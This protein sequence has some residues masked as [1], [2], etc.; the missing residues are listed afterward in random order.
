MAHLSGLIFLLILAFIIQ[1]NKKNYFTNI[2]LDDY[3]YLV[4]Q[5]LLFFRNNH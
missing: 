2:D 4:I 5:P 3:A 1:I